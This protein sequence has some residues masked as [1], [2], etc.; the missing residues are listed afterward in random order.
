MP[1][2]FTSLAAR[3]LAAATLAAAIPLIACAQDKQPAND[4]HAAYQAAQQAMQRGA[5]DIALLDQ[6]I[7]KLPAG[8]LYIP[9]EPAAR[10]LRA[11]G[12]RPGDDVLG[13]VL[14][15]RDDSHGFIV[16]RF[17]KSGYIKDDDA[18]NWNSA[19]ML[20]SIKEGTEDD[21]GERRKRG[22]REIE[23]VGWVQAPAYDPAAHRLVWSLSSKDKGAPDSEERGVNY[24]TYALGREGY[25]S[26][27][28]VT[29]LNSIEAE[30]PSAHALLAALE[31]KEGKRYGD[32]NAGTDHVAEY[33]LAA[34]IGGLAAKKLGLFA[35]FAAFFV[36][37]A[38][39]IL[40]AGI[41]VAGVLVKIFRGKR[42]TETPAAPPAPPQT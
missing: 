34:L 8:F 18:K 10:L 22:M 28:L 4:V 9:K 32:F 3:R 16:V 42:A 30:K 20:S 27:N 24:N 12:N 21:N 37:F 17:I 36:K 38:K 15:E 1:G 40:I 26:M 11:M 41:A 29:G 6:A 39:V 13:L 31:Y 25:F 14:Q 7:L 2:S 19:E 5:A 23:V 33:G 35:V